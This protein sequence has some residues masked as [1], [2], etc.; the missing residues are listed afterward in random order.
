MP[1]GYQPYGATAGT[2]TN[3]ASWGARAG[4]YI[5][6]GLSSILFV[7]PAIISFFAGPREYTECTIDGE[8]SLCKLPTSQGWAI[9]IVLAAVGLVAFFV[10]YSRAVGKTG[11]FWGHRA[12]GI[13]I[14]DAET[15]G[16]IGSGKAFGRYLLHYLDSAI[17]YL[18]FLWPLWDKK[19]QTWADKI[20]GSVSVRA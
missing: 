19:K 17:C 5:L 4:G 20:V 6:N 13:R 14:V 1:P 16:P 18:G 9:I 3:F 10:M 11:Q 8:A 2:P 15:G 12:A 7:L